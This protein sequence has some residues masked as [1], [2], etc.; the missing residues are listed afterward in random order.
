MGD[1]VKQFSE[2]KIEHFSIIDFSTTG[3]TYA[4][5]RENLK[6]QADFFR[7]HYDGG[8]IEAD[9][10]HIKQWFKKNGKRYGL[11]REFKKNGI[12]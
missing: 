4:E 3:K 6:K 12:I 5:R 10:E 9:E 11:T 8:L 7:S 1:A 2:P